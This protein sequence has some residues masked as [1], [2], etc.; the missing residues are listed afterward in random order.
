MKRKMLDAS[1]EADARNEGVLLGRTLVCA[2]KIE[3]KTSIAT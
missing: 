3:E 1:R 2:V